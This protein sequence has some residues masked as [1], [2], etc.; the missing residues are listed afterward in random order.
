MSSC[1]TSHDYGRTCTPTTPCVTCQAIDWNAN[2]AAQ[3]AIKAKAEREKEMRDLREV[4][5]KQGEEIENLKRGL[6]T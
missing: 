3:Q 1:G 2:Y 5:R 4:V 6:T